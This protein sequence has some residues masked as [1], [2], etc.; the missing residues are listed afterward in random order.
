[1]RRRKRT[2]VVYQVLAK[3]GWELRAYP[4]DDMNN[5][6]G[7]PKKLKKTYVGRVADCRSTLDAIRAARNSGDGEETVLP[8]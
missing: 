1:M 4:V 7:T 5:P 3:S 2:Y 6:I 8:V